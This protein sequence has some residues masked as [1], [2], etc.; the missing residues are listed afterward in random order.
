MVHYEIAVA[1][2]RHAQH[3]FAHLFGV[4][5]RVVRFYLHGVGVGGI[6]VHI[7]RK[8]IVLIIVGIDDIHHLADGVSYLLHFFF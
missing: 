8:H 1:D 6:G 4:G 7:E 5:H 3:I 2:F